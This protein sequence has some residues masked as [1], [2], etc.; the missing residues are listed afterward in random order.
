MIF[1]F[2]RSMQFLKMY[3]SVYAGKSTMVKYLAEK[4]NGITCE[5][6]YHK[7]LMGQLYEILEL[8]ILEN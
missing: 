3:L 8:K 1:Q 4:Y 7:S 6:N 2:V 5:E